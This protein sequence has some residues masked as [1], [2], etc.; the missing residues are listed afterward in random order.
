MEDIL[1]LEESSIKT[2]KSIFKSSYK[3]LV[4]DDNP[5]FIKAFET[6]IKNVLPDNLECLDVAHNGRD[7]IEI[8]ANFPF[9]DYIFI[10]IDIPVIDGITAA[11][12]IDRDY[13]RSST[14]I[15]LSFHNEENL[16]REMIMAGAKYFIN[17]ANLSFNELA[18]VFK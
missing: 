13:Y 4:V 9:Y 1:L 10:D 17:K 2:K 11:R 7:A 15:G 5:A 18:K 14:I 8:V 12:L 16:V 3:V 6:L